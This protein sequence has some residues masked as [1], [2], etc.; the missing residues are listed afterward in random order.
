[1]E[2]PVARLCHT[3]LDGRRGL[4]PGEVALMAGLSSDDIR[5]TVSVPGL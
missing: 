2:A 3:L 1:M 4:E 5:A